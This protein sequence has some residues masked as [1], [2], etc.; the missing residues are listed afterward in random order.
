MS[1]FSDDAKGAEDDD[2]GTSHPTDSG[3][4][5]PFVSKSGFLLIASS[6]VGAN[7]GEEKLFLIK[8]KFKIFPY[9]D[10][11]WCLPEPSVPMG[12]A[13]VAFEVHLGSQI[14]ALVVQ[15]QIH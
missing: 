9:E 3:W 12:M 13:V 5:F 14:P 8:I 15:L 10:H 6:N 11:F 2:E 7:Y 1:I 4:T